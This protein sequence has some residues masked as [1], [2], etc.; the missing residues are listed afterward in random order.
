MVIDGLHNLLWAER[1]TDEE[2]GTLED[3][4]SE[5]VEESG[6]VHSGSKFCNVYFYVYVCMHVG[7]Q[8]KDGGG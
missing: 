5:L 6:E 8:L 7:I 3:T 2:L 4:H 1:L